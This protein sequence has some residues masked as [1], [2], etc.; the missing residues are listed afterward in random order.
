M[1]FAVG[2]IVGI[3]HKAPERDRVSTKL[4][5]ILETVQRQVNRSRVALTE[6]VIDGFSLIFKGITFH[7]TGEI[8]LRKIALEPGRIIVPL[9]RISVKKPWD[10]IFFT[11]PLVRK[12]VDIPFKHIVTVGKACLCRPAGADQH[13]G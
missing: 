9:S 5:M 4:F 7:Q 6:P 2:G 10:N 1:L 8:I 13:I 3:R 12:R 11:S